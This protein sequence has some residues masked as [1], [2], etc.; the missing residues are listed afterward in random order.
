M[1]DAEFEQIK[2]SL[3]DTKRTIACEESFYAF[4][5]EAWSNIEGV[6][7]IDGWHLHAL[8]EHLEA[9]TF[10]Y[11]SKLLINVPPRTGKTSIISI[12]W[13]AWNWIINPS[14]KFVYASYATKISLDHSRLCRMLIESPW[15]QER[16]GHIVQ[17]SKDQATKGHFTNTALGHRIATSVSAGTTALGGDILVCLPYHTKIHTE[18]GLLEIGDI[19]E[20]R[21][22]FSV[23]TYNHSKYLLEHKEIEAY[24]SRE[25][26]EIILIKGHNFSLECTP[27]HPIYVFKKGYIPASYLRIGDTLYCTNISA[28]VEFTRVNNIVRHR[29]IIGLEIIK[30]NVRVYNIRIKDNHNY[31]ANG[32]LVHNCDDPNDA[33]DGESDASREAANDYISRV[34]PSRLNAG[35]LGAQVIVQQRVH[36]M[37][38]SGFVM[39]KDEGKKW[40]SL[41]LPMEFEESRPCSTVIL[42]SSNKKVWRDPRQKEG[43][44]LWPN[45]LGAK[46]I[47]ELKVQMG[48]Y[49][50]AG[51]YQ[52]RPAPEEGGIIKK[53]WF[54]WWKKAA[55]PKTIQVIQS[56]DTAL[57]GN[58]HNCWSACTTWGLFE[59]DKKQNQLILLNL[60]RGKVEFPELRARAKLLAADYRDNGDIDL[61]ADGRHVPDMIL[62]E[63]KT[64]G[65]SLIQELTRA[66]I[67]VTRFDP[68][69]YGDKTQRVR[70]ITHLI[71]AGKIWLPARPPEYVKLRTW[72]NIFMTECALF[73]NS[74][75][76]D[77]VDTMTQAVLRLT[78]SGLLTHPK[79][80]DRG[81]DNVRVNH[82]FY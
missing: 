59:D 29:L 71:E 23:L 51:Q 21:L 45:G 40:V 8:C 11:I 14:L 54:K 48:T 79:D 22:P 41:I 81:E 34:W 19:V 47:K 50:Y 30:K 57:E 70:L 37:D 55:P 24:E 60:W 82:E 32:V 9:V 76:R 17:I 77:L 61:K 38:V 44:L 64:S 27:N 15:Y 78:A 56:W 63:A 42:P 25:A 1:T 35:G 20:N 13:P 39:D 58:D 2:L 72:A 3:A 6:P 49:N 43:E 74:Q 26:E 80:E 28:D 53:D 4:A 31:F 12:M 52:Q 7:F 10:G 69:K 65:I 36:E 66:G 68:S 46:K 5:K 16:W 73:P 33:K 18:D 67:I 75:S 62:V